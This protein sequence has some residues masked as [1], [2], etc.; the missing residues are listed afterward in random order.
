MRNQL[1]TLA[2]LTSSILLAQQAQKPNII[3]ILADDMG[4]SDPGCY[5]GEINTPNIDALANN[6]MRFTQFY[7]CSRSCPSRASLMTGLYAQ[8]VG[9]TGMGLSLNNKC[10]TIP[11]ALKPAGYST[12]MTGKWHLSLTKALPDNE[13]QLK[14]MAHQADFGNFAPL[15]SYPCNRGFDEH[16]GIIWGVADYFDPFSLVHNETPVKTVPSD[17][18]M[19]DYVTEKTIALIDTFSKKAAPYF[20]YVAYTAPHWPV[21]AK[22]ED[23][24]KYKGK[25]DG[26]WDALRTSR[27]NRMVEMGLIDPA[28]M[29][30]SHNE[31]NKLWANEKHKS[32][33]SANMEVHAAMVDCLDQGIGKI[34]AKLKAT[35][36][37]ENTIIFF[38]TDNG[39]SPERYPEAGFDRPSMTRSGQPILQ[40][41][42]YPTPGPETSASTIGEG[43]AG[44]LNTPFRYWKSES[45]HGGTATPMI[46]QWPSGLKASHGSLTNQVVHVMDMM[47]TCLEL[48]GATYPTTYKGNEIIPLE[49][50]SIKPILDGK[51][52]VQEPI[53]WE[54]EGGRA[55]RVGNWR[56]VSLKNADWQLFDMANDLSETKNVATVHPG[57]V[58]ELKELWNTW[59]RKVGLKVRVEKQVLT[60]K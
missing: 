39:A 35:G 41:G 19:T 15:A 14:W 44:A 52:R 57:K 50:Q 18:Y 51:T 7:N 59:A 3:I 36:Q 43:W 49:S 2:T 45:F 34:V 31:S 29:P 28:K 38:M 37:Y 22:P 26:G 48:A 21:Q 54:H 6:G 20:L 32:W 4:Y 47:P 40:P 17:F 60:L 46:V 25:Y 9:I 1:L 5:G 12:G 55:V 10:I 58:N 30:V 16:Y 23:I 33:E 53:Y 8:Q 24:A 42:A 13:D 56:L 11:E 27:Y